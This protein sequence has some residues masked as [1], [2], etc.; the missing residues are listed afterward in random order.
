MGNFRDI[1]VCVSQFHQKLNIT[2]STV[3][4]YL[5][6]LQKAGLIVS[7][8]R[9]GK[10]TYYKRDEENILQLAEFIPQDI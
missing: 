2:Q 5:S 4:Q 7:S 6:I 9:I 1:G 3:S 8:T 10:W